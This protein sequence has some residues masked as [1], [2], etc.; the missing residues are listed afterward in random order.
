MAHDDDGEDSF[1]F[2]NLR[3]V[4]IFSIL[5]GASFFF[6]FSFFVVKLTLLI[7]I[8]VTHFLESQ[9]ALQ[10]NFLLLSLF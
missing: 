7:S 4:V 8:K 9:P 1:P 2:E 6:F 3:F 10:R 5:V